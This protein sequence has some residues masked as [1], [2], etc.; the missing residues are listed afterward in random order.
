MDDEALLKQRLT[1]VFEDSGLNK[2]IRMTFTDQ[3][4]S[5]L[6]KVGQSVESI[7]ETPD[8]KSTTEFKAT[9]ANALAI[10]DR[11]LSAKKALMLRKL[12]VSGELGVAMTVTG[13]LKKPIPS[14]G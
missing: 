10:F 14:A 12:K 8:G 9:F 5:W 2:T 1:E 13:L 11:K 4:T 7:D 6:V 3:G